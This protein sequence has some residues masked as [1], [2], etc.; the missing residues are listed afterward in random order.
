MA[1]GIERGAEVGEGGCAG[2]HS[3]TLRGGTG[4]GVSSPPPPQHVSPHVQAA[5][6]PTACYREL[7]RFPAVTHAAL[8]AAAG[9]QNF[10]LYTGESRARPPRCSR[11]ASPVQASTDGRLPQSAAAPT[12][13]AAGSCA[14]AATTACGAQAAAASPSAGQ[15]SAPRSTT[16]TAWTSSGMGCPWRGWCPQRATHRSLPPCRPQAPQPGLAYWAA[17]RRA[18]PLP[19]SGPRAAGGNTGCP[20]HSSLRAHRG[21][22][23]ASVGWWVLWPWCAGADPS[24][25]RCGAAVGAA[26]VWTSR[27]WGSMGRSTRRVGPVSCVPCPQR[28][29]GRRSRWPQCLAAPAPGCA[30]APFYHARALRLLGLLPPAQPRWPAPALP[31]GESGGAPPAVPAPVHG[32]GDPAGT[33]HSCATLRCWRGAQPGMS[34]PLT[35]PGWGR[36]WARSPS[37]PASVSPARG[38][39]P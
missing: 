19:A 25:R 28:R 38:A 14:S 35:V 23:S 8:G 4:R 16:S 32:E 24:P 21:G 26:T 20:S 30:L 18:Q 3:P 12:C 15:R 1:S 5:G 10:L 27:R 31:G 34:Q 36:G 2:G 37:P 22:M 29:R 39:H 17:P 6:G 9:A 33:G 13:P 7:S 11:P